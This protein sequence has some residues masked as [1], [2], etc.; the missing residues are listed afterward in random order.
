MRT[1]DDLDCQCGAL[2]GRRC[3][4]HGDASETVL[5]DYVPTYQRGTAEAA[6]TH[7][8][9]T[10]RVRVCADCADW[11]THIPTKDGDVS[12]ALNPWAYLV[13]VAS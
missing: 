12:D 2:T 3:D 1:N 8:G 7:V 5:V 4:W 10:E 11:I 13:D 9:L 6:G